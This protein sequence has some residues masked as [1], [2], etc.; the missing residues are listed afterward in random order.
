MSLAKNGGLDTL[1]LTKFDNL[2]QALK[3]S[4]ISAKE[5]K[6]DMKALVDDDSTGIADHTTRIYELSGALDNADDVLKDFNTALEE[7]ASVTGMSGDAIQNVK[8][9]FASL[10]GYDQ[11]TLFENTANGV[12]LN[13]DALRE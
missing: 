7:S 11:S 13:K 12:R 8:S 2:N 5:F 3:D 4:G 10:D 6:E 9:M 1:D